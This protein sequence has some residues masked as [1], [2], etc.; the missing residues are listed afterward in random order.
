M[1]VGFMLVGFTDLGVDAVT[2]RTSLHFQQQF[3]KVLN[4]ADTVA[5]MER[6]VSRCRAHG[7]RLSPQTAKQSHSLANKSSCADWPGIKIAGGPHST[8]VCPAWVTV[9]P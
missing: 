5:A 6:G 4:I 2:Q 3:A 7:Q 9:M 8:N 1:S